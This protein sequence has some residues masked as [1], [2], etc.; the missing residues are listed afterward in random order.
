MVLSYMGIGDWGL[1]IDT[2]NSLIGEQWLN[3]TEKDGLYQVTLP[4][5]FTNYIIVRMNGS[6]TEN[7]W[8]NKWNQS[9][10]LKYSAD[11]NLITATGWGS[12]DKFNVTESAK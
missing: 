2:W 8:N 9:E 5:E 6:S 4:D 1:G 3:M 12:G 7:N 10:N 11:K